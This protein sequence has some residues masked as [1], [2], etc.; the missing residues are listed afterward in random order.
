MMKDL[1]VLNEDGWYYLNQFRQVGPYSR[2][3]LCSLLNKN[4]LTPSTLVRQQG[5]GGWRPLRAITNET[6]IRTHKKCA[7]SV[8]AIL[9]VFVLMSGVAVLSKVA[10]GIQPQNVFAILSKVGA[11]QILHNISADSK[12]SDVLETP[13]SNPAEPNSLQEDASLNIYG[14]RRSQTARIRAELVGGGAVITTD[15]EQEMGRETFDTIFVSTLVQAPLTYKVFGQSMVM[16]TPVNP[17]FVQEFWR[18]M[19]SSA[20][21]D[22]YELYL[23]RFPSGPLADISTAR[24]RELRKDSSKALISKGGPAKKKKRNGSPQTTRTKTSSQKATVANPAQ[25]KISSKNTEV[26][27]PVKLAN[28]SSP[29]TV[30]RCRGGN[31]ERCRETLRALGENCMSGANGTNSSK[32]CV[33]H[34]YQSKMWTKRLSP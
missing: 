8:S 4:V 7:K 13:T 30:D 32:T 9:V 23:R 11:G 15:R 3:E 24:I 33:I 2:S 14:P 31:A 34:N 22:R 5:N 20:V 26:K 28:A 16:E 27:M 12:Y 21:V 18:S 10:I 25:K 17:Q 1:T 19:A 6:A 29:Q